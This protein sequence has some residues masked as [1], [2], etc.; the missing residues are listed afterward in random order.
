MW[1]PWPGIYW[2]Y[3]LT[4]SLLQS[5]HK[6][7]T[8]A[9]VLAA[10]GGC[11]AACHECNSELSANSLLRGVCNLQD[12]GALARHLL[13]VLIDEQLRSQ[14]QVAARATA[15]CFTPLAIITRHALLTR[16]LVP[17]RIGRCTAAA[18]AAGAGR[19]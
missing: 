3:S 19:D 14:L 13:A 1:Q 16:L 2:Q 7:S 6:S 8:E 9:K 18:A 17:V 4:V 5:S 12:V 15:M 11:G 10:S